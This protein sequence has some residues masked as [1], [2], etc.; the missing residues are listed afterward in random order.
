MKY[1]L[2]N[3]LYAN[4]FGYFWLPCPSCGQ[5]FGGHES[6]WKCK[7]IEGHTYSVCNDCGNNPKV[8]DERP[9]PTWLKRSEK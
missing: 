6:S 4:L 9:F 7:L 8:I 2:F 5:M 1:R 3:K